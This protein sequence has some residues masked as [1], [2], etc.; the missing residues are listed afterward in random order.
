MS[1]PP[2]APNQAY[3][4]VSPLEV[5]WVH[6]YLDHLVD[7]AQ[8]G[9]RVDLPDMMF[10]LRHSA[11]GATFLFDLGVR[12]DPENLPI[13]PRRVIEE[14]GI[15][16]D[17]APDVRAAF[18]SGGLPVEDVKDVCISHI[19]FDHTGDPSIFP[20]ATFHLGADAEPLIRAHAPDFHD[21]I[22][23]I[24]VPADRT[25]FLKTEDWPA[26][27]PFPHALDFYGD[28]SLYIVDAAGHVP[29]HVNVLARTSAD[30][31][32]VYLAGD[33]AHD[34]RVLRGEA[35]FAHHPKVGCMHKDPAAAV[36]HVER[37]KELLKNPRVRVLLAHDIPWY[38]AN[39]GGPAF[40]PGTIPSL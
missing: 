3:C 38:N 6:M 15:K 40:W 16:L 5:G 11:T 17:G 39:K 26:L 30:G 13:G 2:P 34:W 7:V 20:R 35:R 22:Y 4:K 27:G 32:W 9:E 24:D 12:P 23:A 14:M 8:P 25:R 18:L 10:V 33:S 29:G 28:G 21:T 19:H 31:G 36:A 1:L 37:I